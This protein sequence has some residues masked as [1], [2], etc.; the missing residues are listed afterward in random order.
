MTNKQPPSSSKEFTHCERMGG[1]SEVHITIQPSLQHSI[2][3]NDSFISVLPHDSLIQPDV[4]T[5]V[6]RKLRVS[7]LQ[8]VLLL[9]PGRWNTIHK[10][11]FTLRSLDYT[12]Q[13]HHDK[14]GAARVRA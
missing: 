5:N 10:I 9:A 6:L 2:R 8:H 4:R 7:H 13:L 11:T 3:F 14:N 1:A 12:L